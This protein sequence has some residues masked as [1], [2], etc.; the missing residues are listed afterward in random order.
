MPLYDYKCTKCGHEFDGIAKA[1]NSA[2]KTCPEC[3]QP[4]LKQIS[5]TNN[6]KFT[7]IRATSSM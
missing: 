4:A 6:I 2:E 3:E 5:A 7:G 1:D